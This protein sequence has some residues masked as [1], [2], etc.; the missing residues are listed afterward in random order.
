MLPGGWSEEG[1]EGSSLK[2]PP[3]PDSRAP[4]PSLTPTNTHTHTHLPTTQVAGPPFKL[5]ADVAPASGA[6]SDAAV[7]Q[8]LA[9]LHLRVLAGVAGVPPGAT[10]AAC[11]LHVGGGAAPARQIPCMVVVAAGAGR[12]TVATADG[13]ASAALLSQLTSVLGWGA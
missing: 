11:V 4:C 8:L 9:S 2:L 1:K 3:D 6:L 7:Q 5:S 13:A 12:V 10:A